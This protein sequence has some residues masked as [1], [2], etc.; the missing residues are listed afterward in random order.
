MNK[1]NYYLRKNPLTTSEENKFMA[2]ISQKDTQWQEGVIEH[3]MK[4][5]T[6]I[7]KQDIVIVLDLMK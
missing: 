5:N 2:N 3:M 6:T 4:R 7:S 1:I